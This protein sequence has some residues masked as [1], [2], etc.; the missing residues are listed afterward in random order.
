MPPQLPAR[1][2][3]KGG[4]VRRAD[5]DTPDATAGPIAATPHGSPH[6]ARILAQAL[7]AFALVLTGQVPAAWHASTASANKAVDRSIPGE[8]RV[9]PGKSALWLWN[10]PREPRAQ[11]HDDPPPAILPGRALGA[12]A[13]LPAVRQAVSAG[14]AVSPARTAHRPRAPPRA[15]SFVGARANGVARVDGSVDAVL[16]CCPVRRRSMT[17]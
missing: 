16:P 15:S 6:L 8:Q 9:R 11:L 4:R 12:P 13:V 2:I 1:R 7:L 3:R 14:P 17:A 10:E 5:P